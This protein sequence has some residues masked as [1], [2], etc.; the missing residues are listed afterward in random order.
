M[1]NRIQQQAGFIQ[2]SQFHFSQ[3]M[4]LFKEA[5]LDVRE[6]SPMGDYSFQSMVMFSAVVFWSKIG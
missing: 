6:V 1:Y 4:Q 2:F 5:S 3:A